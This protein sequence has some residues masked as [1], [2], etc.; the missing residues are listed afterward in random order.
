[1]VD[2]LRALG[3]A[4]VAAPRIWTARGDAVREEGRALTPADLDLQLAR[5]GAQ[6]EIPDLYRFAPAEKL[7]LLVSRRELLSAR[8]ALPLKLRVEW[9]QKA[10]RPRAK[11]TTAREIRDAYFLA[12]D[13]EAP[14][15]A[16][17]LEVTERAI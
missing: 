4:A 9:D 10:R 17:D 16:L 15:V 7:A 11:K 14:R 1:A 12:E 3:S 6:E 8:T 13:A 2:E 5:L